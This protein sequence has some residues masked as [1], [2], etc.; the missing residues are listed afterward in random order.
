MNEKSWIKLKII[1]FENI[2]IWNKISF[3][4]NLILT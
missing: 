4:N 2:E 3:E 1:K